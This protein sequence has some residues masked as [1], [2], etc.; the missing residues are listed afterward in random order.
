MQL[1]LVNRGAG[2]L[3]IQ[4]IT[5]WDFSH[6]TKGGTQAC[7]LVIRASSSADTKQEFTIPQAEYALWRRGAQPRLVLEVAAPGGRSST[8]VVSLERADRGK[9]N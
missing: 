6:P 9:G 8:E 4:R 1:H 3:H 5:L 2:D 7:S